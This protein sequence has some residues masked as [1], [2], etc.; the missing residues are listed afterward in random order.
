MKTK[1]VTAGK[2]CSCN[3]NEVTYRAASFSYYIHQ[4]YNHYSCH[5]ELLSYMDRS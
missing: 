3:I 2:K 5:N 4:C 1:R